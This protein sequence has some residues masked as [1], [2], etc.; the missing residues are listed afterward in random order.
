MG[1]NFMK[2]GRIIFTVSGVDHFLPTEVCYAYS[3]DFT[4]VF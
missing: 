4:A 3:E 1:L 2:F